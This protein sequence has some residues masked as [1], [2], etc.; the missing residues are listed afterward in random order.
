VDDWGS[1]GEVRSFFP[2]LLFFDIPTKAMEKY[3]LFMR[4][5]GFNNF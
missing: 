2:F 3:D 1:S 5:V 4:I